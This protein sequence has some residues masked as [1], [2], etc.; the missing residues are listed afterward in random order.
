LI[1]KALNLQLIAW[2]IILKIAVEY[3][4][5]PFVQNTSA[6]AGK[7]REKLDEINHYLH[8]LPNV[9]LKTQPFGVWLQIGLIRLCPKIVAISL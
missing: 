5:M 2:A 9:K 7:V 1:L 3:S 4:K 6:S 8:Y